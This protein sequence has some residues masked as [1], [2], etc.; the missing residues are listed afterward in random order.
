SMRGRRKANYGLNFHWGQPWWKY[1]KVL[2]DYFARLSYTLSQGVRAV[3]VLV[4][5]PMTSVWCLYTPLN[6]SRVKKTDD[7][8]SKL[9]KILLRNH[10]D[11]EIGD[12]LILAHYAKIEGKELVV[13]RARYRAVV[14]P[15]AIN[16]TSSVL[17]LLKQ[18]LDSGGILILIGG[19]PKY[20]DGDESPKAK[21]LLRRAI[22]AESEEEVVKILKTVD[23]EVVVDGDAVDE[24]VLIHMRKIDNSRVLFVTNVDRDRE[25]TLRIGVKGSYDIELWDPLTGEITKYGGSIRDSRTWFYLTLKPIESKLFI[26]KPGIPTKDV[27]SE[28]FEKIHEIYVGGSCSVR[29]RDLN[30][31][32]LDYAQLSLDGKTWS[33]YKHLVKIR[34]ELVSIGFG[35]EYKLRFRFIAELKPIS[36]TYLVIENPSMYRGVRVNGV[37]IDLS[38][39]CG[40]WIDWNFRKYDITNLINIGSD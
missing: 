32:V 25:Y 15:R 33:N 19:P 28:V 20:V 18:Y 3:E 38:K 7:E 13:G 10:I 29:R 11:F 23:V 4:I 9:L 36:A 24:N 40:P 8:F 12:E 30:I 2:E 21:E 22:V 16:I 26:L 6:T 31:L 39:S 35:V 1:N 34:E 17:E 27:V 5:S 37:E 14:L